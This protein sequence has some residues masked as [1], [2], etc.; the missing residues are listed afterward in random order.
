MAVIH[1]AKNALALTAGAKTIEGIS[2]AVEVKPRVMKA[3]RETRITLRSP[4]LAKASSRKFTSTRINPSIR[5]TT[6]KKLQIG[7]L[8]W[9][10]AASTPAGE[11]SQKLQGRE[12]SV[13][14][15]FSL[16]RRIQTSP[17]HRGFSQQ[18]RPNPSARRRR[19]LPERIS[20]SKPVPSSV[21]QA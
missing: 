8:R 9:E 5:P 10:N 3:N 11:E 6:G 18:L 16:R 15:S 2:K 13:H 4:A 1:D 21:A 17:F 20:K 14:D 12:E 19:S 7:P